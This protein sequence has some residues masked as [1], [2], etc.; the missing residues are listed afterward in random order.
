MQNA[1][2]LIDAYLPIV[3]A[4]EGA[5]PFLYRDSVGHLT[6]GIGHLVHKANAYAKNPKKKMQSL[7]QSL[8]Y[9]WS[10]GVRPRRLELTG[11]LVP[12]PTDIRKRGA[13]PVGALGDR[14]STGYPSLT[15]VHS[16]DGLRPGPWCDSLGCDS[17][18]L[19]KDAALALWTKEAT[20]L[21]TIS[22]HYQHK[23][24]KKK[25]IWGAGHYKGYTSFV[26]ASDPAMVSLCLQDI[27]HHIQFAEDQGFDL[28]KFPLEAQ[29]A[30]L[31]L[32]YQSGNVGPRHPV[33]AKAVMDHRWTDAA[34]LCPKTP[35][36]ARHEQRVKWFTQAWEKEPKKSLKG[37][38]PDEFLKKAAEGKDRA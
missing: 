34:K 12:S 37:M 20:H 6:I 31:D 14:T 29:L 4:H 25:H 30:V 27:R 9:V 35:P 18:S 38:S 5:I 28:E 11:L 7:R 21:L 23:K 2:P 17:Q 22:I 19:A 3:R 1:E 24:Q 33:F 8:E 15:A 26:M 13:A 36:P 32:V 16:E 10:F